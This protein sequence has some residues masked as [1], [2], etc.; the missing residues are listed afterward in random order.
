[1]KKNINEIFP[2]KHVEFLN[3]IKGHMKREAVGIPEVRVLKK[4]KKDKKK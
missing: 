3:G 2:E 4:A 1:M